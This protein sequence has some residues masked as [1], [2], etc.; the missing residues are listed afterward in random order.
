MCIYRG[1]ATSYIVAATPETASEQENDLFER[2]ASTLQYCWT[3]LYFKIIAERTSARQCV[4]GLGVCELLS[5]CRKA[6]RRDSTEYY[7]CVGTHTC[8]QA[9]S[10]QIRVGHT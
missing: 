6:G 1:E 9:L 2:S 3:R 10:G 4:C 7:L 5:V 8:V